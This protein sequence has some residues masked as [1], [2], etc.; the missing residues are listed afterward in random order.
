M[1][2]DTT[3]T[4]QSKYQDACP[5]REASGQVYNCRVTQYVQTDYCENMCGLSAVKSGLN[6]LFQAGKP[7]WHSRF[8]KVTPMVVLMDG[9]AS[10]NGEVKSNSVDRSCKD[11]CG[12][13]DRSSLDIP[14]SIPSSFIYRYNDFICSKIADGFYG[15][16]YKVEKILYRS[17]LIFWASWN[18]LRSWLKFCCLVFLLVSV[19][20]VQHRETGEVMVLKMNKPDVEKDDCTMLDEIKLMSHLSHEN[21]IRYWFGPIF[22]VISSCPDTMEIGCKH[23]FDF[24]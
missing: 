4:S 8:I 5:S 21:V 17:L 15:D 16:V 10:W 18:S 20:Q 13:I 22:L 2:F 11:E 12:K 6:M 14:S 3:T 7:T 23:R 9:S 19:C 24:G 1:C